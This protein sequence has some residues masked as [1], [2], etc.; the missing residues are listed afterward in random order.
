[1][2]RSSLAVNQVLDLRRASPFVA[3]R[4]NGKPIPLERGRACANGHTLGYWPSRSNQHIMLTNDY[5][6]NDTYALQNNDPESYP[7]DR[8]LTSMIPSLAVSPPGGPLRSWAQPWSAGPVSIGW[9]TGCGPNPV[10][11][12]KSPT[13]IPPGSRPNGARASSSPLRTTGARNCPRTSSQ[14]AY[15]ALG[16]GRRPKEW[17]MRFS[18]VRLWSATL[19]AS[20][21]AAHEVPCSHGRQE[22]VRA[23]GAEAL[24]SAN[25]RA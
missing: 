18:I 19:T 12:E 25:G 20:S 6:A 11:T 15:G 9:N 10:L 17:P 14:A 16:A 22:R 24:S 1:M 8:C 4:L 7:E 2:F 23:T 3:Y 5:R 21:R 13:M